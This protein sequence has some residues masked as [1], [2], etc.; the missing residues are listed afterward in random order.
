MDRG[1]SIFAVVMFFIFS[2][3]FIIAGW[4]LINKVLGPAVDHLGDL[5]TYDRTIMFISLTFVWICGFLGIDR[6]LMYFAK[7][8]SIIE[9][10]SNIK[11]KK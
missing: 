1:K 5:N 3:V 10:V 8:L 6:I 2:L 11:E 7:K 9:A 4:S